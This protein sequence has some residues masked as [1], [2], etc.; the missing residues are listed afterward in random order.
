MK[1]SYTQV[2]AVLN[3]VLGR[4]FEF[5]CSKIEV[6]TRSN[7]EEPLFQGPGTIS[8]GVDGD[9]SFRLFD[10]LQHSTAR[11]RQILKVID[12]REPLRFFATD[13]HM[14]EWVGSW[15]VPEVQG[16]KHSIA[17][18]SGSVSRISARVP[19]LFGVDRKESTA[20]YYAEQL[21]LTLQGVTEI[22]KMRDGQVIDRKL[23]A[24][25][26]T[27][28]DEGFSILLRE[29]HD[30]GFTEVIAK[31]HA[32]LMPPIVE[33]ALVDSLIYVLCRIC[34]PRVVVRFSDDDALVFVKTC[35]L[36]A[37][38]GLPDPLIGTPSEGTLHWEI[39]KAFLRQ[40]IGRTDISS[41]TIARQ[42]YEV[43]SASNGTV[44]GFIVSLLLAI[45][46]LF[47]ALAAEPAPDSNEHL[48]KLREHIK[49]WIGN[50]KIKDRALGLLAMLNNPASTAILKDLERDAVI[51]ANEAASWKSLRPKVAHG[52]LVDV[53][54][55]EVWTHRGRLITMFHRL[56]LRTIGYRGPITDF[57]TDK[58]KPV[59]FNW[60]SGSVE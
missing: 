43:I 45:E 35:N 25:H 38:T 5:V 8:G 26:T 1:R 31:N 46:N 49:S 58:L 24:D 60:H 18:V 54:D 53:T 50:Q 13:S 39:F 14:T 32:G 44:H 6:K 57:S 41:V 16:S 40:Y 12:G 11:R 22:C 7:V 48:L 29:S 34:R 47:T 51:T 27:I 56:V 33:L 36:D 9:I 52:A 23:R 3:S 55:Q 28:A 20:L 21:P 19:F 15:F 4:T 59:S 2:D 37:R 17:V 10:Q 30:S 42:L